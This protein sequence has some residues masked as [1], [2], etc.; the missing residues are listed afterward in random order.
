MSPVGHSE[1]VYRVPQQ[2]NVN[3][4]N[5]RNNAHMTPGSN[6]MYYR[7]GE[8]G[9]HIAPPHE[10]Q[11][12]QPSAN[13]N[14]RDSRSTKTSVSPSG[15]DYVQMN[16]DVK[17]QHGAQS[18]KKIFTTRKVTKKHVPQKP[19]VAR[20]GEW[21]QGSSVNDSI[22]SS[23]TSYSEKT[24]SAEV[25][26][27]NRVPSLGQR[28]PLRK[29]PSEGRLGPLHV[30]PND[31]EPEQTMQG[32][33]LPERMTQWHPTQWA[34]DT[35]QRWENQIQLQDN[36]VGDTQH[37]NIDVDLKVF[38]PGMNRPVGSVVQPQGA[39]QPIGPIRQQPTTGD[40][41]YQRGPASQ[42]QAGMYRSIESQEPM[43]QRMEAPTGGAAHGYTQV[44][45][46]L[47]N[48]S[49]VIM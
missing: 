43:W 27:R 8:R 29:F 25:L 47:I 48:Y 9:H 28:Q 13:S 36:Y 42:L 3:V 40:L 46:S 15:V 34:S 21:D 5:T 12:F 35:D 18:Y 1:G 2:S 39:P 44:S 38:Q 22:P 24:S 37:V 41:S 7:D 20:R 30:L 19:L 4:N 49:V 33:Y 26:W 10:Q 17:K 45:Y 11:P 16:K 14:F 31:H 6:H 23:A 32:S